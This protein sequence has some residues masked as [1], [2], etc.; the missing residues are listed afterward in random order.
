MIG[1]LAMTIVAP[2]AALLIQ[3]AISR[4]RE[5]QADRTGAQIA[6]Q[7]HGLAAA[8]TKLG[9]ASRRI[10]LEANPQT[11]HLFIVNPL[12]GRGLTN[13]FSTHP[14]LQERIKRL[15]ALAGV[16]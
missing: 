15:M 14:P 11:A 10:P 8:L 16:H 6:G 2:L 4:S 9:Q 7:P 3:A 1:L 13:L 5:Y 12:S